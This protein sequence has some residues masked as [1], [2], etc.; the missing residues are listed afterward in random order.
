MEIRTVTSYHV[1]SIGRAAETDLVAFALDHVLHHGRSIRE[2]RRS[3]TKFMT[4]IIVALSLE[5]LVLVFET[6]QEQVG[7]AAPRCR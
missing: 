7:R 6:K 1:P 4:I 5:A 3:L 2:A